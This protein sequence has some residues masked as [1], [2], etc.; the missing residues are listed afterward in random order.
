[1]NEEIWI[2]CIETIIESSGWRLS[3]TKRRSEVE[4]EFSPCSSLEVKGG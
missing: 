4:T 3:E 1:M 2:I